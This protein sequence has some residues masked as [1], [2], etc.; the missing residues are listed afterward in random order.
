MFSL[1]IGFAWV[2][3]MGIAMN[4]MECMNRTLVDQPWADLDPQIA[5]LDR[6]RHNR[7]LEYFDWLDY[8]F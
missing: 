4:A 2:L 1:S 6:S 7:G 5:L 8:L 3:S